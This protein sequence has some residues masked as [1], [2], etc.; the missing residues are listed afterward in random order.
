MLTKRRGF[1]QE[2]RSAHPDTPFSQVQANQIRRSA[3]SACFK[4]S[5]VLGSNQ[6][7]L[8]C[9]TGVGRAAVRPVEPHQVAAAV[10]GSRRLTQ[11]TRGN[12]YGGALTSCAIRAPVL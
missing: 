12:G 11:P 1:G 9:E 5:A 8:P 2:S 7:P 6:W 4:C 3:L 10:P